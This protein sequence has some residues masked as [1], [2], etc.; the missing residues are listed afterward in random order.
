MS[1]SPDKM[2]KV[3]LTS[4]FVSLLSSDSSENSE[5][6]TSSQGSKCSGRSKSVGDQPFEGSALV[7]PL[8]K[9]VHSK[10]IA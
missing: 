3:S 7:T 1:A 9:P 2:Q 6:G 10:A 4:R 5:N 8:P